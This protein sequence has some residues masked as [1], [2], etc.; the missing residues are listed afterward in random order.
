[1]RGLPVLTIVVA[2]STAS[3]VSAILLRPSD[4]ETCLKSF[5]R[6]SNV[7]DV[8]P[9][10]TLRT[11]KHK[12]HAFVRAMR[13]GNCISSL[14]ILPK[15]GARNYLRSIVGRGNREICAPSEWIGRHTLP[16]AA[17]AKQM[18]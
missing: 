16:Y 9:R 15:P 13:G 8:A 18:E 7:R 17:E 14:K 4:F 6:T 1:M 3:I 10:W 12:Q 11:S 2:L 5:R